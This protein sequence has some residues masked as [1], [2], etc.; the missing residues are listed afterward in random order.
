MKSFSL[1]P[2][3][4]G[5]FLKLLEEDKENIERAIQALEDAD[6]E[7]EIHAKAKSVEE[8]VEHSQLDR[9]QIIKTLIFDTD[10]GLL[11]VLCPGS[12]RVDEEK[13][14]EVVGSKV[15]MADPDKIREETG[16][17]VGG[18]APFDLDIPIYASKDIPEGEIRPSAGSRV[19]GVKI[20]REKL[21]ETTGAEMADIS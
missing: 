3:K 16:Y 6:I 5:E 7:F 20:D 4:T 14:S 11:A 15:E 12:E 17:I 1:N 19:V 21:L 13:L 2:E 9:E 18:V 8:S 10:E